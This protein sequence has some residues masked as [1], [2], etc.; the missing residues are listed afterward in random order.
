MTDDALRL[1]RTIEA[2]PETVWAAWTTPSGLAAWWWDHWPSTT[3]AVDARVGGRYRIEAP[4]AG[5][6][7]K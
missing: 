3:Y 1:D 5:V 4:E 2:A 6:G 7:V